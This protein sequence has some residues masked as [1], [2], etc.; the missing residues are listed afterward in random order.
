MSIRIPMF[1]ICL[2]LPAFPQQAPA[3]HHVT[4]DVVVTDKSG[5]PVSGL[6]QSDFTVIDNKQPDKILSFQAMAA[7]TADPPMEII[8]MVDKVNTTVDNFSDVRQQLM[9]YLGQNGQ[10]PLPT[11]ITF[12]SD[13]ETS[14]G[15]APT[16]DGKALMA[17]VD[18]N[19]VGLRTVTRNQGCIRRH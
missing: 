1:L 17:D 6:P 10:L 18:R 13:L 3:D 19:G 5:K 16:L 11:S 9:K 7:Q 8:L 2:A 4:L 14:M 15:K 12:F